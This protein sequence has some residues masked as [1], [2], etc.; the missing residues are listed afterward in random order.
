[1][2]TTSCP[3]CPPGVALDHGRCPS[4]AGDLVRPE[5]LEGLVAR[6][7]IGHDVFRELVAA[8]GASPLACPSCATAM[9]RFSLKGAAFDVC[10]RCGTG[11]LGASARAQLEGGRSP[12]ARSAHPPRQPP[13]PPAPPTRLWTGARYA[14]APVAALATASAVA[15]LVLYVPFLGPRV[16]AL[17]LPLLVAPV[18]TVV[19]VAVLPR[20]KTAGAWLASISLVAACAPRT[21]H[22][23]DDNVLAVSVLVAALACA[24]LVISPNQRVSLRRIG[25]A[26]GVVVTMALSAHFALAALHTGRS[27][28]CPQGALWADAGGRSCRTADGKRHGPGIIEVDGR[29]IERGT[30]REGKRHGAFH[31]FHLDADAP[32]A[33]GMFEHDREEGPWLHFDRKGEVEAAGRY[34]KGK[35]HGRWTERDARGEMRFVTYRNGGLV[36]ND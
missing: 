12:P 6:V 27:E 29:V 26:V 11:F 3:V 19:V 20:H 24:R 32:R 28:G 2:S 10:G 25:V 15:A 14:L 17:L 5:E 34:V 16:A 21:Y 35:R 4:C 22:T 33:E 1:M 31:L 8:A 30:W 9:R 13:P 18:S 7:G 23:L 36:E